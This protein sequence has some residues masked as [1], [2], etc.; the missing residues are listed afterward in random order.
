MKR[1][2]KGL[3]PDDD[4][5]EAL[6]LQEY[7]L[8]ISNPI[9]LVKS[10]LELELSDTFATVRKIQGNHLQ[11]MGVNG[12]LSLIEASYLVNHGYATIDREIALDSNDY[13]EYVVYSKLKEL[14][15]IVMHARDVC[16]S[17]LPTSVSLQR[18]ISIPLEAISFLVPWYSL[19]FTHTHLKCTSKI[20]MNYSSP[21]FAV[22]APKKNFK[23]TNPGPLLFQ[24]H[25]R[26][27]IG[28]NAIQTP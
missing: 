14:G 22:F 12:Q 18:K 6:A 2:A 25:V 1:Q 8:T 23:K 17:M 10:H 3:L 15:Y 28:N 16:G 11:S 9:K 7:S 13:E 24:V 21:T 20:R 27:Y 4:K 26:R 5:A 19:H